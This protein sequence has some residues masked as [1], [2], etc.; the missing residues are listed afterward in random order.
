M[1]KTNKIN[2]VILV[3][4]FL[5]ITSASF[6]QIPGFNS[7]QDD[8]QTAPISSILALGLIVGAAYGIKKMK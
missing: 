7:Q 5:L 3:I 8:T 4:S 2:Q 1:K 6:A